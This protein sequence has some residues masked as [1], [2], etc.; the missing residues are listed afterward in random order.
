MRQRTRAISKINFSIAALVVFTALCWPLIQK[1]MNWYY[2]REANAF[3]E[4]I[5][6]CQIR[7]KLIHS[8][9]LPFGTKN[10]ADQLKKLEL[11]LKEAKYFDFAV[12]EKDART[13]LII[14]QLK[15]QMI[16]RWYLNGAN[17]KLRYMYEKREGETGRFVDSL[18]VD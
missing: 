9:Y 2:Q 17:T 18:I 10:N 7:H 4:K 8:Q 5:K 12:V 14:A 13:V 1:G 16:K 3:F 15:P 11:D 6:D